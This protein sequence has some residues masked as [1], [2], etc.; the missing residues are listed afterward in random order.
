MQKAKVAWDD[1]E[2]QW[3]EVPSI[4]PPTGENKFYSFSNKICCLEGP[5]WYA[6]R[7]DNLTSPQVYLSFSFPGIEGWV[8]QNFF[9][10]SMEPPPS[11]IFGLPPECKNGEVPN[12]GFMGS[13]SIF[14]L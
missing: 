6:F 1:F 5:F 7:A 10:I 2:A 4:E 13:Q 9:D 12:C 11:Q 3:W 14:Q 8:Q